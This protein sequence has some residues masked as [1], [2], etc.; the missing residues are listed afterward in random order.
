MPGTPPLIRVSLLALPE[1]YP[2]VLYC[3]HELFGCVGRTWQSVTGE[4][5][6]VACR[7]APHLVS[8]SGRPQ[9]SPAG[10]LIAVEA[11]LDEGPPPDIVI[12]TDLG[13][14][15]DA[16]PRGRWQEEAAWLRRRHEAGAVICSVCS[17]ALFLAEAGLLD[18][19][20]ATTHWAATGL[21]R[22]HYPQVRLRAERILCPAGEGQRIVTAG[23]ASSWTDL[24]LYLVARFAGET[25]ARRMGRIFI[26]GDTSG[27]QQPFAAL[28]RPRQHEDAAVGRAQAWIALNYTCTHPVTRMAEVAGL[29]ERTFSRRFRKATGYAPVDYVQSLRLE[30]AKQMLESSS[31]PVDAVALEVGYA[32]P[33]FFRSLFKRAVGLSPA[34]YRQRFARCFEPR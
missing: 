25:E 16:H 10:L 7:F 33:A 11:A 32:D 14:S 28:A 6:D 19:L 23:G 30:E 4:P 9:R 1:S 5:E 21:F 24:A 31:A 13:M 18:G 22:R 12:V 20:E 3:L 26:I 2:A 27:G 8:H 34:R 17:G 15:N 29:S